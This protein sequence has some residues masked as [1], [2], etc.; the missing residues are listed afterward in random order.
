MLD[1]DGRLVVVVGGGS[2]GRR[3][4]ATCRA[5]GATV[6]MIDPLPRPPDVTGSGIEWVCERYQPAHLDGGWLAFACATPEVNAAVV[7]DA[8]AR[9]L[10]V[11]DA[12]EP[13]R[14]GVALPAVGRA[15]R[16]TVAVSSG[17]AAP[18]LAARLRDQII[19]DLDPAWGQWAD[20]LAELRPVVL[21]TI[22]GAAERRRVLTG[23]A[24]PRW[25]AVIRAEGVERVRARMRA[26]LDG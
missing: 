10:W 23:L 8:T 13:G 1:L 18:G 7:A 14:G 5:A 25:L 2:V 26:M 12:A 3:K 24:D 4:A 21:A 16:L 17:G 15:G 6:R 11:C 20:L 19:G 22:A 9:R